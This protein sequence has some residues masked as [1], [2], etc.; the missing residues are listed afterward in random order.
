[1]TCESRPPRRLV[2]SKSIFA[3]EKLLST[4]NPD[5]DRDKAFL[6]KLGLQALDV[7]T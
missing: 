2:G 3:D 7:R 1:M 6:D 5:I 4:K